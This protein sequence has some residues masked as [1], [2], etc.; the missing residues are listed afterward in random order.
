MIYVG[1]AIL[2]IMAVGMFVAYRL[3][4]SDWNNG[5][6]SCEKG[7]WRSFDMDSQGGR[8]YKCTHCRKVIWITYPFID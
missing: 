1:I 6:C 4:K 5:A 3:E 8:G 7:W 2:L